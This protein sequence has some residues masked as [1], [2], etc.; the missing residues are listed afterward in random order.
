MTM[1][2]EE[3]QPNPILMQLIMS[4]QTAA[5]SQLGK[6]ASPVSGKI[7]RNL[8]EAKFS[9]DILNMLQEKTAGNLT[10][11]EKKILDNAVYTLQMN[12][13][14]EVNADKENKPESEGSE[15]TDENEEATAGEPKKDE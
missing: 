7:E 5:W 15:A 12:Y 13:I 14:D 3:N 9:I 1:S 10:D 2:G 8:D 4:M 11:E 6:I